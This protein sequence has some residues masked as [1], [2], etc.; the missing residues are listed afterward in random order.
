MSSGGENTL[1]LQHV[2]KTLERLKI[3]HSHNESEKTI[4]INQ[5]EKSPYDIPVE[6]VVPKRIA[7]QIAILAGFESHEFWKDC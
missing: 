2:L 5:G 7:I 6:D 1:T 3:R 4:T